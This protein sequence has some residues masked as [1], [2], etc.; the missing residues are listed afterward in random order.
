[1]SEQKFRSKVK[2]TATSASKENKEIVKK[3]KEWEIAKTCIGIGVCWFVAWTP[4]CLV[5]FF[6]FIGQHQLITQWW[7][8]APAL[9]AKSSA[10]YN[11]VSLVW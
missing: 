11:P 10:I 3:R 4:Y 1:M 8:Q 2:D 7:S 5:S 6:G 9:F